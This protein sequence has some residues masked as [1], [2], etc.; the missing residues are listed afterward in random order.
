MFAFG[1]GFIARVLALGV[2]V[3][4]VLAALMTGA[5]AGPYEDALSR[6]S[7]DSFDQTIDGINEVVASGNALAAPVITALQEAC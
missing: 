3:L 7:A 6:L 5:Q 2:L 1:G 4:G